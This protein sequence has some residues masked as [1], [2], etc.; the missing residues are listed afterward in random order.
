MGKK[1]RD[2]KERNNYLNGSIKMDVGSGKGARLGD[3]VFE[4][5]I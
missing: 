3:K 2:D 1:V 5:L 4:A